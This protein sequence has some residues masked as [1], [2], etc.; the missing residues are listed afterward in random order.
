MFVLEEVGNVMELS[1]SPL[2]ILKPNF[3]DT[4]TQQIVSYSHLFLFFICF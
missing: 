3:W 1:H 2:S 4:K